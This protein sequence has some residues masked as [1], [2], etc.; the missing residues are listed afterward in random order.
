MSGLGLPELDQ[1]PTSSDTV[2]P[3]WGSMGGMHGRGMQ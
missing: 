1:N 3:A 2:L